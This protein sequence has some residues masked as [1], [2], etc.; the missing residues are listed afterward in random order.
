[1]QRGADNGH[2]REVDCGGDGV[3][4][5]DGRG[6]GYDVVWVKWPLQAAAF[7]TSDSILEI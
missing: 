4:E 7:L 2:G 5:G 6:G 1:M 3:D